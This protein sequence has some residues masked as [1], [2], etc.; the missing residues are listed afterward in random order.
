LAEQASQAGQLTPDQ[1]RERLDQAATLLRELG[2][3]ELRTARHPDRFEF[4]TRVIGL[5]P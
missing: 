1:A 2:T 4:R 3:L 5:A